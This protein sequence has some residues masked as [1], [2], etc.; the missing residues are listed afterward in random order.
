MVG[1]VQTGGVDI[2][3][4]FAAERG[5]AFVHLLHEV[6]DMAL[7]AHGL[8]KNVARLVCGDDE[9]TLQQLLD[10]EDLARLDARCAAVDAQSLERARVG[11]DGLVKRKLTGI[12]RL[13]HQQRDDDLRDARGV[14]ARLSVLVV[15]DLA[16][17]G[18][19][20]QGGAGVDVDLLK[21][22][23]VRPQQREKQTERQKKRKK[24]AFFHGNIPRFVIQ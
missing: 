5:G 13:E 3:R 16:R 9:H 1:V 7:A 4:V 18:L 23:G 11:L 8:G 19:H 21:G 2:V 6:G 20:K 15:E 12:H 14:L 22:G 17:S 10:R 24:A